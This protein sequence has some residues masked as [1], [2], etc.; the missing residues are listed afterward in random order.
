MAEHTLDCK[1]LNCPMPIVRISQQLR[2]MQS[3]DVLVVEASDPAFKADL[4]AWAKRFGHQ[5]VSIEDGPVCRAKV[6]KA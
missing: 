6:V 4:Q 3:G 1:G 5:I 2:G